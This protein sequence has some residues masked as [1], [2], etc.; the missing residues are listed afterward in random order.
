MASSVVTFNVRTNRIRD[1]KIESGTTV[2]KFVSMVG[3]MGFDIKQARIEVLRRKEHDILIGDVLGYVLKDGDSV[4]FSTTDA[5]L[6]N[7]EAYIDKL[8]NDVEKRREAKE[9]AT[10][11]ISKGRF[12]NIE[13]DEEEDLDDEEEAEDLDEEDLDEED[14]DYDDDACEE[15]EEDDDDGCAHCAHCRHHQE[16]ADAGKVL[17]GSNVEIHTD[18]TGVHIHIKK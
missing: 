9:K 7:L 11:S 2:G 6:P 18:D 4:R 10:D 8:V 15:D 5:S 14:T 13:Y 1:I 17:N 3:A 12:I 16:P